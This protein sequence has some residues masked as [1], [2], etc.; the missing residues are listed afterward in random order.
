MGCYLAP[1]LEPAIGQKAFIASD[2]AGR[3]K[4]GLKA[5][6][7]GLYRKQGRLKERRNDKSNG[8]NVGDRG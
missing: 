1:V 8:S 4:I 7:L 2:E 5:H 6:D 3:D